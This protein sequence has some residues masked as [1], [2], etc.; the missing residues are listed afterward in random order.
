VEAIF[1]FLEDN[2]WLVALFSLANFTG[3]IWSLNQLKGLKAAEFL[4]EGG[5]YL[6]APEEQ[7][8]Y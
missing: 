4:V 6:R 8:D 7:F 1:A 5:H 3:M 2:L